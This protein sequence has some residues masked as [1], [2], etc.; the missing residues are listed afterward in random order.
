MDPTVNLLIVN[1]CNGYVVVI[2]KCQE[3]YITWSRCTAYKTLNLAL[4]LIT[5]LPV[6]WVN[7]K[8]VA[9]ISNH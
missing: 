9:V 6:Y 4:A 5:A 1:D 3:K 2:I 8:L 7:T